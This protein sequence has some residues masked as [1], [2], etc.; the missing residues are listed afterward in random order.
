M[1]FRERD[2]PTVLGAETVTVQVE[3]A[4]PAAEVPAIIVFAATSVRPL[5]TAF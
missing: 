2:T 4:V 3:Y 1:Y 5:I